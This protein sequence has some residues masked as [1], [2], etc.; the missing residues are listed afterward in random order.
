MLN[1][2]SQK[3]NKRLV[4]L[5]SSLVLV[6]SS[7]LMGALPSVAAPYDDNELVLR[8]VKN[9]GDAR[10][11][12][13][14]GDYNLSGADTFE[15]DIDWGTGNFEP[16]TS[17]L[18]QDYPK[19]GDDGYPD[20]ASFDSLNG[21]VTFLY[22]ARDDA[23][24]LLARNLGAGE[25]IIRIKPRDGN[26]L[27]RYGS[28]DAGLDASCR[29][30]LVEVIQ[31]GNWVSDWTRGFADQF[32]L[33]TVP[34]STPGINPT[35]FSGMFSGADAFN[36]PIN[37]WNVSTVSD[38]SD[39]FLAATAFN[40]DI[41]NWDTSSA[42][43]FYRMFYSTPFN[44]DIG[45]WDTSSVTDFS[46]MF[47]G[48]S[49]FNQDIG[50][51][52]TSSATDF[53]AMFY[54]ATAFNQY[55]GDWSET[56]SALTEGAVDSMLSGS[57]FS[58]CLPE[59]FFPGSTSY[60]TLGLEADHGDGC[61][62]YSTGPVSVRAV[63]YLGPLEIESPATV[64]QGEEFAISGLRL[65]TVTQLF[66]GQSEIQFELKDGQIIALAPFSTPGSYTVRMYVPVNNLYLTFNTI[67]LEGKAVADKKLNVGTFNGYVAVYAKGYTGSTLTWKIAGKWFKTEL[68][69][70]YHVF[71]RTTIYKNFPIN[72]TLYIDGE[73]LFEKQV[74][75]K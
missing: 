36:S 2:D 8:V 13:A 57:G 37:A 70:D 43:T 51:W 21:S 26:D 25:H 17:T 16:H 44:Q 10:V 53:S 31:W 39:M 40:Q 29:N 3:N 41:G 14:I 4:G 64:S 54:N 61:V 18:S 7:V 48:A 66:F 45:N 71:Q 11:C 12:L 52:D 67:L 30:D 23:G 62:T 74:I 42:T 55:I 32:L 34:N 6:V 24:L 5:L 20:T 73:P 35:S 28:P 22:P 50:N 47:L 33:T 38:F 63:P 56:T 15:L 68:T 1:S 72:V 58:Y 46:V 27:T 19:V 75:T 60:V 49:A 69:E 59:S 9:T 65:D